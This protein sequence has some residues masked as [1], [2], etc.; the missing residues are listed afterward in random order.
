MLKTI[1]RE[2]RHHVPF[3]AAGAG[4]GILMA[5]LLPAISHDAART[6]FYVF[7]PL[8]VALSALVTTAM[9]RLYRPAK[10]RT[11]AAVV[12]GYVGSVV[13][14]TVSDSLV[15]YLGELL[16]R[17]PSA[18]AHIGFIE[19]WWIVN[20]A[21]LLGIGLALL[22]PRTKLPHAGHVLA[23]TAASLFHILMALEAKPG[24]LIYLGLFAFLFLAVWIPCCTSDIIFPLLFV[25]QKPGPSA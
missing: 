8:H 15:P 5:S 1:L 12:I 6:V 14:G 11:W 3:T 4:A 21:A 13:L 7:H 24:L 16:F 25:P 18:H 20:P 2:L 9:Y 23:S 10:A 22:W 17:L 19:E